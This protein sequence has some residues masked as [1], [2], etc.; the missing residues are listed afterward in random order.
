MSAP[1]DPHLSYNGVKKALRAIKEIEGLPVEKVLKLEAAVAHLT[2]TG[3]IISIKSDTVGKILNCAPSRSLAKGFLEPL[4]AAYKTRFPERVFDWRVGENYF[5]SSVSTNQIEAQ[6]AQTQSDTFTKSNS[7]SN[8]RGLKNIYDSEDQVIM[9]LK[10]HLRNSDNELVLIGWNF[11]NKADIIFDEMSKRKSAGKK[12]TIIIANPLDDQ[13][14]KIMADGHMTSL[15]D[16]K[17]DSDK[18]LNKIKE[19]YA[20]DGTEKESIVELDPKKFER[21]EVRLH[22]I[23]LHY[24]GWFVLTNRESEDD[25]ITGDCYLKHY[26]NGFPFTQ[27]PVFHY[28]LAEPVGQSY[29]EGLMNILRDRASTIL[30]DAQFMQ[31]HPEL[32]GRFHVSEE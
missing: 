5:E 26:I 17:I 24:R 31:Q 8:F 12:V 7:P 6:P 10:S 15:K 32:F 22:T 18:I 13:R 21:L 9:E 27:Y 16:L 20:K 28:D 30:C 2:K 29:L 1:K 3:G 19:F 25:I 11:A 14:M 23:P 4:E